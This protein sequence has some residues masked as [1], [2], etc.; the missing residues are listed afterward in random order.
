MVCSI[1]PYNP[2]KVCRPPDIGLTDSQ[3]LENKKSR[4][5]HQLQ[6]SPV[7]KIRIVDFDDAAMREAWRVTHVGLPRVSSLSSKAASCV[8]NVSL[9]SCATLAHQQ[10]GC[11]GSRLG[12]HSCQRCRHPC[13]T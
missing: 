13:F 9:A 3:D 11:V 7:G 6:K 1:V 4:Q 5:Q 8:Q 12:T 2:C 10:E